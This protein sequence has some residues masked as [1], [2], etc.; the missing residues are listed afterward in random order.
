M[1]KL[2]NFKEKYY[3]KF[4]FRHIFLNYNYLLVYLN[5]NDYNLRHL[6]K[7]VGIKFI[8]T[9]PSVL[10][11][12]KFLA[13][14]YVL[15]YFNEYSLFLEF[16]QLYLQK[17]TLCSII[18]LKHII[19]NVYYSLIGEYY[20]YNM[21]NYNL[22]ILYCNLLGYNLYKLICIINFKLQLSIYHYIKKFI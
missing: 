21:Q 4:W 16:K 3:N 20:N 11:N 1:V 2:I 12:L 18:Y 7:D 9:I 15:I 22:I 8:Y 14:N 19:N 10:F 13:H 6:V 17:A 5:V